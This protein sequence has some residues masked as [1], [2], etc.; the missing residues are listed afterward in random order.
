MLG[1]LALLLVVVLG[2]GRLGTWQLDRATEQ[3]ERAA[4]RAAAIAAAQEPRPLDEVLLPQQP[5]SQAAVGTSVVVRGRYADGA[6]QYVVPESG[7]DGAGP[8]GLVLASFVVGEG[9]GAG[10]I[11]PV[12]R[13]WVAG[14]TADVGG[15]LGV[16]GDLA[17]PGGDVTVTGYLAASE[18]SLGVPGDANPVPGTSEELVSISS[19]QLANLW[20]SP[21]YGGYLR[22]TSADPAEDP[23]LVPS[24]APPAPPT[25]PALRNLAYAAQWW[26]FGGFAVLLWIRLLRDEAARRAGGLASDPAP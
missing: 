4:G 12:V 7:P 2:F 5:V 20:G 10:A 19:G 9:A 13:G 8:G 25:G 15:R 1:L 21:I 11:L 23:A 17:V 18:A 3:G 24:S 16:G 6:A 14:S 26:I 22:L